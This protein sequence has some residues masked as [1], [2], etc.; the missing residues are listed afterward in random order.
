VAIGPRSGAQCVAG[1]PADARLVAVRTPVLAPVM[2]IYV[3]MC[4]YVKM[5]MHTGMCMY[6]N[7]FVRVLVCM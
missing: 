5:C 6:V 4:M 3:N 1:V 7:K 2:F